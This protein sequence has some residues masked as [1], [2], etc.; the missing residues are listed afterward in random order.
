M[1]VPYGVIYAVNEKEGTCSV[2]WS[3]EGRWLSLSNFSAKTKNIDHYRIGVGSGSGKEKGGEAKFD[4]AEY[5]E[6]ELNF[7]G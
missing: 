7:E 6:G 4:L 2:E 3:H 5:R 1:R